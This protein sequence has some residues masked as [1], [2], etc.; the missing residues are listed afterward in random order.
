MG[1]FSETPTPTTCL[2]STAVHLPFVRQY[3]PHLYR[4][5]FGKILGVGV[6][7]TFLKK[8]LESQKILSFI[9][10]MA[11]RNRHKIVAVFVVRF[12]LFSFSISLSFSPCFSL[13]PAVS[14]HLGTPKQPTKWGFRS[15]F[16]MGGSFGWVLIGRALGRLWNLS[17]PGSVRERPRN[18]GGGPAQRTLPYYLLDEPRAR[19]PKG[20]R[21]TLWD[22]PH[23]KDPA[24]IKTIAT[25]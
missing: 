21:D 8:R 15:I 19:E 2:K 20:S 3:A 7:R 1:N 22:T 9:V 6:T 17:D 25:P 13:F 4:P 18:G 14:W 11:N 12:W 5:P 24:V 23:P 10:K 16:S